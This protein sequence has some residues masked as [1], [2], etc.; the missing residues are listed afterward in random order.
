M[1]MRRMKFCSGDDFGEIFHVGWFDVDDVEGIVGFFEV[2]DVD[3]EVVG[4]EE[5]LVVGV[6]GD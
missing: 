4:R 1:T 2:P 3:A 6:Y 5:G